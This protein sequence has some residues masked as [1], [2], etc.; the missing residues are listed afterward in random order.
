MPDPDNSNFELQVLLHN[1]STVVPNVDPLAEEEITEDVIIENSNK[2]H[3]IYSKA[4]NNE[5]TR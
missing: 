3:Q 4:V 2:I 1:E 5:V